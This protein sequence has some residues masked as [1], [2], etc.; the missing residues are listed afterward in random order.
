MTD[1]SPS[2]KNRIQSIDVLRGIV[3][4]IMALDHIRDY[5]HIDAM[6]DDPLNLATTTPALYFTR[7]ITHFCAPVFV[8]LSGISIYLQ[9][10]RKTKKELARFLVSRGAWLIIADLTFMSLG[11]TADIHFDFF[12]LETLWSIGISMIILGLLI[13]LPFKMIFAIGLIILFGHNLLDLAEAA[14]GGN[15]PAWWQ[16]M[17]SRGII[18]LWGNH[19]LFI[20]Y[21]F[22]PWTG[23]MLLGYCCGRLFTH[24]D[25]QRRKKILLRAGIAAILFFITLRFANI[26]GDPG[27]WNHQEN[28][29]KTFFSFMNVQK[30]PPSLLFLCATIGPALIFLAL[31]KN[32]AGKLSTIISVYGRVPFFYFIVH[33]YILHLA[34]I[35][36]YLARGH[37]FAEGMKSSSS[38]IV[39]FTMPGEGYSLFAVYGIWIALVFIM[40]LL[41]KWYDNYKK[42][43]REKWWLSYL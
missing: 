5:I 19:S 17:H 40:Y 32:T 25:L 6:T 10:Q 13:R 1:F 35:I 30:Y 22:L 16:F 43:H 37:S 20:L 24:A 41:C 39:K 27:P 18:K 31:V 9:S 7:W 3:M 36:T 2:V 11:L 4:I 12:L 29:V 28:G 33:L 15:I 8:F 26:Y 34:Q 21:P 23:L 14:R 42:N 38:A